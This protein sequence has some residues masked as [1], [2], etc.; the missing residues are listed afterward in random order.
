MSHPAPHSVSV[1]IPIGRARVS[2]R[3][4]GR[5]QRGSVI[6][7]DQ[8]RGRAIGGKFAEIETISESFA[9]NFKIIINL[10]LTPTLS[11]WPQCDHTALKSIL[12][13]TLFLD[14]LYDFSSL[15]FN[16]NLHLFLKLK[17]LETQKNYFQRP[18]PRPY[19]LL[20]SLIIIHF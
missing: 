19:R 20:S 10:F 16:S 3:K 14:Q 15:S 7:V 4:T 2:P 1:T 9:L 17:F 5:R 11:A 8:S 13:E 6:F 18:I 12:R